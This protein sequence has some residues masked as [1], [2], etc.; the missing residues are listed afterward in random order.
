M[1]YRLTLK[2]K[3]IYIVGIH[4]FIFVLIEYYYVLYSHVP[5]NIHDTVVI[6]GMVST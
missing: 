1:D 5:N 2:Q 6:L 3:F 4:I